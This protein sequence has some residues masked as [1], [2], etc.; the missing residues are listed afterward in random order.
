MLKKIRLAMFQA[1][2]L[3]FL[4]LFTGCADKISSQ[5]QTIIEKNQALSQ[6][7]KASFLFAKDKVLITATRLLSHSDKN[8]EYFVIT[9]YPKSLNEALRIYIQDS[10]IS[11]ENITKDSEILSNLPFINEWSE[12]FYAK[13]K[14]QDENKLKLDFKIHKALVASLTFQLD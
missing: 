2:Y 13:I 4:L 9:I 5:M 11:L 10:K 3:T 12:S 8:Y 1:M 7:K 14:K 6:T